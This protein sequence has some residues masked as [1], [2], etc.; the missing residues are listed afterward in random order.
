[1]FFFSQQHDY[2]RNLFRLI[3]RGRLIVRY[4]NTIMTADLSM[5]DMHWLL[6]GFF[7]SAYLNVKN[8]RN[9]PNFILHILITHTQKN[10]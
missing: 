1:M 9:R 8:D 3:H 4:N 10:Q 2:F 5:I 6:L 7:Q